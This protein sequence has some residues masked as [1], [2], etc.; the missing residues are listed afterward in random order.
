MTAG[1]LRE[2]ARLHR[3]G[4]SWKRLD[5]FGLEYRFLARIIRGHVS[6]REGI[7]QLKTA[8]HHFARRQMTWWRR[9][10]EIVW[11]EKPSAANALVRTFLRNR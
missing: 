5:A 3:H 10:D 1:M 8:I 11:I 4:L 2:V 7:T 9:D 6:R